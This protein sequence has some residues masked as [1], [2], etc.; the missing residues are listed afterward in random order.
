MRLDAGT[1]NRTLLARQR[2]LTR[3]DT[4]P[5]EIISSMIGLQAQESVS[6]YLGLAARLA[7]FSPAEVS[8]GL[9]DASLVRILAMRGTVHLLVAEDGVTLRPWVQPM[10]DRQRVVEPRLVEPLAQMPPRGCWGESGGV[11]YGRVDEWTGLP[12]G[13][14]DIEAL[15]LRYLA[16]FGPASAADMT[17]WSGVT[18]LA[19]V[20]AGMELE[21]HEDERGKVVY[22]VPGG[23]IVPGDTPA[24]VR[25]L[26][27]YDNLW[28]AHADRS[29]VT[30]PEARAMWTASNGGAGHVVL[31][32][33]WVVGIWRLRG[34]QVEIG[35]LLRPLT[36]A[37]K[38]ELDE[39]IARTEQL[40]GS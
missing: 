37:E 24:P 16:A 32:G 8:A 2:L 11:V 40:L 4:T 33:G 31:A 17:A 28:L 14:V 29:R 30:T 1:L 25:L 19:P 20:F 13:T 15:V 18:R 9:K 21:R 6:P 26:G 39:E 38:V 12:L 35:E 3:I 36:R 5:A 22:D 10:L 23:S 34:G 7:D 27:T